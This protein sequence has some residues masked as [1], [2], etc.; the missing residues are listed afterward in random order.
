MP[1]TA[2]FSLEYPDDNSSVDIA[3]HF[4]TLADDVDEAINTRLALTGGTLTGALAGTLTT[5]A[6]SSTTGAF[7]TAGGMGIAKALYV[8]TTLNVTGATTLTGDLTIS[9]SD[10]R[11]TVDST[12]NDGYANIQA[13][14]N[15][16]AGVI[17]RTGSSPRWGIVKSNYGESGSNV[18]SDLLITGYS[19]A[20]SSLG[21]WLT[22]ERANGKVT[23][24][25]ALALSGSQHTIK[26]GTPTTLNFAKGSQWGYSSGYR[27]I[28]LGD[29]AG[30]PNNV[31]VA[32]GYDP[33]GNANGSFT[34]NGSEVLF[35]NAVEFTTPNA[36]NNAWLKPLKFDSSGNTTLLGLTAGTANFTGDLTIS[37]ASPVLS[38]NASSG[39]PVV[40]IDGAAG[41]I[42]STRYRTG[43]S[44]RWL[45]GANA[46]AESGSNAGSDFVIQRYN[47]AGAGLGAALTITRSTGTA[48]FSGILEAG[49]SL[50]ITSGPTWTNDT[51]K[52]KT[53]SHV[54]IDGNI[55]AVGG[56]ILF[57]GASDVSLSR[58]AATSLLSNSDVTISKASA[59][60]T[61]TGTNPLLLLSGTGFSGPIIRLT[62]N[63]GQPKIIDFQTGGVMRFRL[64]T[65]SV[66]E[67]GSSVGSDFSIARKVDGGSETNALTIS[68]AT[69]KT[70]LGSVGASAGLELGS[71]GPRMMSGTGSPEGVVTAP[72]GSIWYQSDSTVGVTHWRKATGAGNTGWV[73]MSG[74]TGWR[75]VS[76]SLD[77]TFLTANPNAKMRIRRTNDTV[78][79][80]YQAGTSAT[81]TTNYA[82]VYDPPTGFRTRSDTGFGVPYMALMDPTSATGTTKTLY[83]SGNSLLSGGTWVSATNYWGNMTYTTTETWPTSLPGSAA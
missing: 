32:I 63:S 6:S 50:G 69:G 48:T 72:I 36:A 2:N 41:Q 71:S 52:W 22:I 67:S 66:A 62:A 54:R 49:T 8:G 47:D 7:K 53:S 3:G 45:T 13:L 76:A 33:V 38:I 23:L 60:A 78:Q 12:A 24:N 31:T 9:K 77:A 64:Y 82:T 19:D 30:S 27:A 40:S 42:K 34:G 43:T 58:N 81:F 10:A 37:K 35:R 1:T 61:L 56:S 59:T 15:K 28:I 4:E 80:A 51:G 14:A 57:G 44:L 20:G 73:V 75:D 25:G 18:G 55:Y 83:V 21:N 68:R 17:V 39:D 11:L 5:D 16:Y 70:T 65:D 46:T 79:V 74:D 26:N 29:T